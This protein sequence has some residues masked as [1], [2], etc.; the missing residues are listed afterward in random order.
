MR[1]E[2]A[3]LQRRDRQ[4]QIIDRAGRRSEMENVIKLLFRQEN[5]V[6]DVMFDE[7]ITVVAG[8][9]FDVVEIAGDKVVD[10]DNAMPFGQEPIGQMR[11]EK[12][13][14]SGDDRDG[15]IF[16]WHSAVYLAAA[17]PVC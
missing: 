15:F 1:A 11:A 12:T 2:S 7:T 6:R 5:E 17:M 14:S 10:G 8:E 9:V 3:D 13:R 4:F 16:R